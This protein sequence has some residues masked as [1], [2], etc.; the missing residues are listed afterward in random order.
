MP[1]NPVTEEEQETLLQCGCNVEEALVEEVYVRLGIIGEKVAEGRKQDG[2][3]WKALSRPERERILRI[4]ELLG[5]DL[6][7]L[8]ELIQDDA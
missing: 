4:L 6:N 3:G 5:H 2:T 7:D 8:I 1:V